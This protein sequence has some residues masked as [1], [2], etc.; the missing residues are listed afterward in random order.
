MDKGYKNKFR[1]NP[2]L[3]IYYLTKFDDAI[4]SDF[5]VIAKITSAN[6]CKPI[7]DIINHSTSVCPFE[8]TKYGKEMKILQKFVV[9]KR[10]AF[11]MKSKT[12]F[13]VFEGLSFGEQN[14]NLIKNT[15]HKL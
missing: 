12:F 8:F 4:S 11:K 7:H 14:K 6:L 10:R 13:I 2:L 5:W 9:E 3:V 1:K 15:G